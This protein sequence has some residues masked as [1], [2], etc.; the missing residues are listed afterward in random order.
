M[1]KWG[2]GCLH[3][4]GGGFPWASGQRMFTYG[5][6]RLA[7]LINI[8]SFLVCQGMMGDVVCDFTT[9]CM[10]DTSLSTWWLVSFGSER[11]IIL[12][13]FLPWEMWNNL[14]VIH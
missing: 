6:K 5:G 1:E 11:G 8:K 9:C 2:F 13:V 3:R 12:L 14:E 7:V 10:L 4:G